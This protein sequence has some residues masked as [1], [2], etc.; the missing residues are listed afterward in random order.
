M[1]LTPLLSA[2]P[3]RRFGA[4]LLVLFV[5]SLLS[6]GLSVALAAAQGDYAL[7]QEVCRSSSAVKRSDAEQAPGGDA[8]AMLTTGHCASCHS[9]VP[10]LAPPPAAITLLARTELSQEAPRLFWQAPHTLFAWRQ[11]PARAPPAQH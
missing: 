3:R 6:P 5:W 8:L 7:F 10:D 9:V 4:W 2:Q 1:R 11:A